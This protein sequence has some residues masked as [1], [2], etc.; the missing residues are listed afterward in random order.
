MVVVVLRWRVWPG[1]LAWLVSP[2]CVGTLGVVALCLLGPAFRRTTVD[3][4]IVG[5]TV[6]AACPQP[7]NVVFSRT[8]PEPVTTKLIES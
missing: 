4:C 6:G 1:F 8:L 3:R 7:C 2:G 5:W